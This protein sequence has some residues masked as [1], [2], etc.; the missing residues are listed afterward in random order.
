MNVLV[1]EPQFYSKKDLVNC[2][3]VWKIDRIDIS[4]NDIFSTLLKKKQYHIIFINL[5]FQWMKN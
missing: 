1:T 2:S 3:K 4:C 5:V